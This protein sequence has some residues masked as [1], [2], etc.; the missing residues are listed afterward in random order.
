MNKLLAVVLSITLF[1]SSVTPS[2]AQAVS[3]GRQ[4]VKGMVQS[5][6]KSAGTTAGK[7]ALSTMTKE[8]AAA[9][10]VNA[11]SSSLRLPAAP[12][13]PAAK[14]K[15]PGKRVLLPFRLVNA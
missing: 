7:Q 15:R 11:F 4:V 10:A 14:G 1:V 2:F 8:A 5:G 6:A 13:R 3:A 9:G 12:V